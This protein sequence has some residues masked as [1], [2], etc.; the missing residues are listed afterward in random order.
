MIRIY[1]E[2]DYSGVGDR[3]EGGIRRL[4]EA[5][6]KH[7]PPHGFQFVKDIRKADLTVGHG[8]LY[9]TKTDAP[10]I[11]HCHGLHWSE[12]QWPHWAHDVNRKV[13]E[14]LVR[15]QA[16]TAPSHWV[17][18][19]IT[20]GMLVEPTVIHHGVD[21]AEWCAD[22]PEPSDGY[23]LWDKAR[24]DPVSDPADMQ[25]LAAMLP[26]VRFVTTVGQPS[27]NVKVAGVLPLPQLKPLIQRAGLYLATARETFGIGTLEALASGVPV[28]GW[29]YGGQ[30]EIIRE[31]ETGFLAPY[32]DFAALEQCVRRA[33][34]ERDRL[35]ANA[36]A[37]ARARWQWPDK[38]A[39][40][41]ALYQEVYSDWHGPGPR[42]SVLVTCHNLARY[43]PAALRS[44][45]AQP[46]ADWECLII[47]DASSDET[48]QVAQEFV[49]ADARFSYHCPDRNLGLSGARNFGAA[50]S[51]GRYLINLDADD[52]LGPNALALL[53]SALD[54]DKALHIA[55]G[56]LTIANHEMGDQ[57]PNS[58]PGE[59]NWPGQMAHLNQL[60]YAAL[61]RR[62]VVERSGGYRERCWRAEDAEFWAR[63]TSFGFRA[64]KVTDEPTLIYRIRSDSKGATEY[65]A[66]ADKDGDWTAW[67]PWRMAGTAKEGQAWLK[68]HPFELKAPH[69]I[70]FGAQA[71]P[72]GMEFWNVPHR[73]N[74]LVSVIIPVG[75]GHARLVLDALD[76]LVAQDFTNWEA[77]VVNDTGEAWDAVRGAPYAQVFST[78]GKQGPGV[79]RNVGL[80]HAR[81]PLVLFLDA[82]DWLNAGALSALLAAYKA[83]DASYVY[84]DYVQLASG[85]MDDGNQITA[86]QPEYDQQSDTLL[87]SIVVLMARA[88]ALSVGSF[89]ESL[90][91]WEDF[92]FFIKCAVKGLCGKRLAFPAFT[93][94]AGTGT[95]RDASQAQR[96][97]LLKQLK[98]RYADYYKGK[99]PM[100]KCCGGNKEAV[101]AITDAQAIGQL[102]SKTFASR[103]PIAVQ[104]ARSP[105]MKW[106][107]TQASAPPP[108]ADTRI[109]MQFIGHNTGA[110]TF[111]GK[112]GRQYRGGANPVER[113]AM[114]VGDDVPLL[115][116]SGKWQRVPPPPPAAPEPVKA[117]TNGLP[118][119]VSESE[120]VG[121]VTV[122]AQ[123]AILAESEPAPAAETPVPA[124]R[125]RRGRK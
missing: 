26:D 100:G 19:A 40:Y 44:V 55:Y 69:L 2:P 85:R 1:M 52:A 41:A 48:P 78:S 7:L 108:P 124:R 4:C 34:G 51:K 10:F 102:T 75:P 43:L 36:L 46:F 70:P 54:K 32:G 58:W 94:R 95:R 59:F 71:Q 39:Q 60:H 27:A 117:V 35:S 111:F 9:P 49:K 89:D 86:T 23:V 63:V 74:P 114:V 98:A 105:D 30:V 56:N 72:G 84:T 47:D 109:K 123:A 80:Q 116:K 12:Y 81:A 66:Y 118:A 110:I 37:D 104:Q 93:Y 28:V 82:D 24:A 68:E 113:F 62:E 57:R 6:Y 106:P 15:A 38:I 22:K 122:A 112:D 83:G 76:S 125:T 5:M 14:A 87:H 96:P 3:A 115:E 11:S 42:V 65:R 53:S 121:A 79:A 101:K 88:D 20:R 97:E 103:A 17:A 61:L 13:T 21:A 18:G 119:Q 67:F 92:D 73:Q 31:G 99:K 91:G 107:Y 77:I 33:L 25:K 64:A 120:V 50:R 16:V 8:V 29:R 45:Q 90:T